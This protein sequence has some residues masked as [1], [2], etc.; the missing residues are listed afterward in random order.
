MVQTVT[1]QA[2]AVTVRLRRAL[3]IGDEAVTASDGT[4]GRRQREDAALAAWTAAVA[5][6]DRAVRDRGQ[7]IRRATAAVLRAM[8]PLEPAYYERIEACLAAED[9]AALAQF[10]GRKVA[11][12]A[13]IR[14]KV[15]AARN[16]LA[17]AT[18]QADASLTS[19]LAS[20]TAAT[21]NLIAA[22][23]LDRAAAVTGLSRRRLAALRVG[24]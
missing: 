24:R 22:L 23:G 21:E 10:D 5:D 20:R 3:G 7:I 14:T 13:A 2:D 4:S 11:R 18:A 1:H 9:W 16:R 8:R 12:V 15:D 6:H 17:D 19:A